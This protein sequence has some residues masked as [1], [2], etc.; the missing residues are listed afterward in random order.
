MTQPLR[1]LRVVEDMK[2]M[3]QHLLREDIKLV[4]HEGVKSGRVKVDPG[5]LEQVILNLGANARDAMSE[6][7]AVHHRGIRRL[8]GP[9]INS[10]ARPG[11][12]RGLC[13]I[14]PE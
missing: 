5:Q 14:D 9:E 7:G 10:A 12:T 1:V 13:G 11:E 3:L 6:G 4:I 8:P 2:S